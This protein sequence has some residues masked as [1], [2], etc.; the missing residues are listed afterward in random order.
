[1]QK[2]FFRLVNLVEKQYQSVSAYTGTIPFALKSMD[3][4]PHIFGGVDPAF[5]IILNDDSAVTALSTLDQNKIVEAYLKGSIDIEGDIMQVLAL[6]ELFT[7]RKGM[8][9]LWR[10]VQPFLFGQVKS[11]KKWIANHYDADEDFFLLFLDKKYRAYSQAVYVN[12]KQPL[13]DAQANKFDFALDAIKAKPGHRVLDIGSGWG[14]FVE[15]AGRK[16]IHVTSLTISK[17][18]QDYVQGIIDREHLPCKVLQEHFLE[19]NSVE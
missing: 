3:E 10:F 16:G 9:F 17:R 15:Y 4:P 18:S 11:D 12:D 5:V 19:H 6:R 2:K 8:R 7:D 1:M 13:E 14:S